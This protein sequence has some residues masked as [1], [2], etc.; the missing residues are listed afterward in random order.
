MALPKLND[1]VKYS[2]KIPS[3][4]QEI[5]FRPFLI[6]EEK[7]LL[8]AMESKDGKMIMNSILDTIEACV[9]DQVNWST[10]PLFDIEYIFLQIRSKS[11]GETSDVKIKCKKCEEYNDITVN[12]EDIKVTVP[13]K[14]K[15]IQLDDQYTLEMKYPSVRDI[16]NMDLLND[17]MTV[18]DMTFK[19]ISMCIKAV[20]T[21]NERIELADESQEEIDNFINSL[22]SKQF[23]DLKKFVDGIPQLK[24]KIEFACTSCEEPNTVNLR[25][26][27]DFF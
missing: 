13:K 16:I 5:R 3:S 26:T 8:L 11:V 20:V 10:L 4:G 17:D 18:T 21:E 6:K 9:E 1:T 22:N 19:S 23:N 27:D 2:I 25:G 7:V 14:T 15:T 12:L 24:H